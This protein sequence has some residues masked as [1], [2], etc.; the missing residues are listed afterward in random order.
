MKVI[1]AKNGASEHV[2]KKVVKKKIK[3]IEEEQLGLN[4]RQQK[5]FSLFEKK[6]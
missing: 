1:N 5:I 2:E 4:D 6:N 3:P